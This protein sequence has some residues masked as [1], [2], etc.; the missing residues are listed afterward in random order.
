MKDKILRCF[1][2]GTFLLAVVLLSGMVSAAASAPT[3][4]LF[5]DNSTSLYDE[6]HFVINWTNAS[7]DTGYT[8]YIWVNGVMFN[9]VAVNS[10][11]GD[12]TSGVAGFS[13]T[14][15]TQANYTF[16]IEALNGTATFGANATNVSMYIDTTSPGMTIAVPATGWK[17][18]SLTLHANSTD[19]LSNVTSSTIAYGFSNSTENFSIT[20]P[21]TCAW[22]GV[23]A[24]GYNCSLTFATSGLADGNYTLWFN[25]TDAVGNLGYVDVAIGVDNTVPTVSVSKSTSAT[26]SVTVD[27]SCTDAGS[28]VATC[29]LSSSSGTFSGNKVSGLTC[30]T[31]YDITIT[32]TDGLA[33]SGTSTVAMTTSGC[34]SNTG[35]SSSS[36][37][38]AAV[39]TTHS[40]D[41][42]TFS[43]GYTRELGANNRI[44]VSV[45]G[46]IHHIGVVSV[47]T[48]KVTIEIASDPVT[49]SLAPGEDTKV[50]VSDD[51]FYDIYVLLNSIVNGK[52]DLT[53]QKISEAVP[54]GA[55][56]VATTGEDLTPEQTGA[57]TDSSDDEG[58]SLTW[59]WIVI[60]LVVIAAIGLGVRSRKQ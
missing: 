15:A 58:R 29:A 39:W 10:S 60:G 17:S 43:Q 40:V 8:V 25:S 53:I 30:G 7:V 47:A 51:G 41:D 45:G 44:Q 52:A 13:Y 37:S 6:G 56:S 18:G 23:T 1:V 36:G 35:G 55:G 33:N 26:S 19:A 3:A 9:P 50:D 2:F 22:A 42:A 24:T 54:E 11:G 46:T 59:L 38:S 16:T 12:V 28:G 5:T 32:S 27:Y 34:S 14:N 31:S 21:G 4:V 20:T 57:G 49:V 48:D